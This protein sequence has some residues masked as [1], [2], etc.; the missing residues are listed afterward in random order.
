MGFGFGLARDHKERDDNKDLKLLFSF[1]RHTMHLLMLIDA[2]TAREKGMR[3]TSTH[4]AQCTVCKQ[5]L[6]RILFAFS[7]AV[8]RCYC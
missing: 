3:M 6:S 7:L 5:Q 1:L 2:I 4:E 8:A